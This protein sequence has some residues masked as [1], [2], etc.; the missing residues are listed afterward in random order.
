MVKKKVELDGE[1]LESGGE[2]T[3]ETAVVAKVVEETTVSTL[4]GTG[5]HVAVR[6]VGSGGLQ[7]DAAP[8]N[9]IP[10]LVQKAQNPHFH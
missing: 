3:I 10:A 6:S 5:G 9:V 7:A 4:V 1:V 2:E 8:Q